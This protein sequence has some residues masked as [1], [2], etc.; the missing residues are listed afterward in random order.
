MRKQIA[1]APSPEELA[2]DRKGNRATKNKRKVAP[3]KPKDKPEP[4]LITH[5]GETLT[6]KEWSDRTGIG[7]PTLTNRMNAGWT[8]AD[9][10][11]IRPGQAKRRAGEALRAKIEAD[12]AER[13][14]RRRGPNRVL[15]YNGETLPL[16]EWA[17][18]TGLQAQTIAKR[19][20]NGWPVE[21]ALMVGDGRCTE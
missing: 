11:T 21:R 15:T 17:T 12:V 7:Q 9:A 18:R 13:Q 20:K 14:R 10:L 8:V 3:P 4:K 19:I 6:L 1:E 5:N 2:G 16:G